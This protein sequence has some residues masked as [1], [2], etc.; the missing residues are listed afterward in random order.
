VNPNFG[1]LAPEINWQVEAG[2]KYP[3][4]SGA[5]TPRKEFQTQLTTVT[6]Q[7][8]SAPQT[9]ISFQDIQ[10]SNSDEINDE[11]SQNIDKDQGIRRS[12]RISKPS[13][14]LRDENW[15]TYASE[16]GNFLKQ[17]SIF[18]SVQDSEF[19]QDYVAFG[20]STD[21]DT[22][23]WHEAMRE[24]DKEQFLQAMDKEIK[25]HTNNG[26]WEIVKKDSIPEGK[27]VLPAV[28]A[29]K[30]KRRISTREVYKWKAR[31]NIDGSKQIKGV[32]LFTCG[33]VAYNKVGTY[34]CIIES[35]GVKANRFC[36]CLHS[37]RC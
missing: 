16:M 32:N 25:A 6:E 19:H 15:V 23:Y 3:I 11:A 33:N 10:T 9:T 27:K 5:P 26:V 36:T 20:A 31:I 22:L 8:V 34:I 14:I 2:F 13:A 35:V 4:V 28:W 30:R 21:L 18:K 7:S 37:S 24:P 1:N 12:S 17:S 29:M